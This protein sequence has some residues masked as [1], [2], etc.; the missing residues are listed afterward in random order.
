MVTDMGTGGGY[1]SN[2]SFDVGNFMIS[3]KFYTTHCPNCK[4]RIIAQDYSGLSYNF[5]GSDF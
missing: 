5:G 4:C 2:C 3:N 1:C